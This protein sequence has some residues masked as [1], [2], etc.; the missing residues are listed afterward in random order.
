MLI[1]PKAPFF[2]PGLAETALLDTTVL[3]VSYSL[4]TTSV[5]VHVTL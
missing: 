4:I 5:P 2:R 1:N 3:G